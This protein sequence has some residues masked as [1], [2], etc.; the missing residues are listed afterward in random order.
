MA[1]AASHTVLDTQ[2][3][4]LGGDLQLGNIQDRRGERFGWDGA[5]WRREFR[6]E[7]SWGVT[8]MATLL[9]RLVHLATGPRTQEDQAGLWLS[10]TTTAPGKQ[11]LAVCPSAWR[12]PNNGP[13]KEQALIPE[14]CGCY[15][16]W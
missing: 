11:R 4:V 13:P 16:I 10:L 3:L 1:P 6:R 12:R 7:N 9:R 15:F 2:M 5:T 14:T 8:H